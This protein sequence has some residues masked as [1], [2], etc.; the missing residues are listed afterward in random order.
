MEAY[1]T[2]KLLP[3]KNNT[4]QIWCNKNQDSKSDID[5]NNLAN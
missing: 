2:T 1:Y 3:S 5:T 4:A